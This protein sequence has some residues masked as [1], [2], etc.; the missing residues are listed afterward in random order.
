MRLRPKE[1]APEEEEGGCG[2]EPQHRP[3]APCPWDLRSGEFPGWAGRGCLG[4]HSWCSQ[5]FAGMVWGCVWEG[6]RQVAGG[7]WKKAG[8]GGFL[9]TERGK[10]LVGAQ[11]ARIKEPLFSVLGCRQ[12]PPSS[13]QLPGPPTSLGIAV[14]MPSRASASPAPQSPNNRLFLLGLL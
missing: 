2:R 11:G 4:V 6:G 1:A 9:S 10:F 14:G 13:P 8:N 7:S 3:L 12:L 5:G